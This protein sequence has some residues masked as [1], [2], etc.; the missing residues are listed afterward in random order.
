MS[1]ARRPLKKDY[2]LVTRQCSARWGAALA[3][4]PVKSGWWRP[5][6]EAPHRKYFLI[7]RRNFATPAPRRRRSGLSLLNRIKVSSDQGWYGT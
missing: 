5:S 6:Q 3:D 1:G 7:R 2:F 4:L